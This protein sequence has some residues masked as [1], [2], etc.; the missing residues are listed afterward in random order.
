MPRS[1]CSRASRRMSCR[2]AESGD[3]SPARRT[4]A[5]RVYALGAI[6]Q[7]ETHEN[8]QTPA[9]NVAAAAAPRRRRES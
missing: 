7:I 6:A 9:A 4:N 8:T 2:A 3:A 5:R 1:R